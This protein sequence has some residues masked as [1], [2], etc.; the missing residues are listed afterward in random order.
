MFLLILPD[1]SSIVVH[2]PFIQVH[3]LTV[4]TLIV[5]FHL[6]YTN[7]ITTGLDFTLQRWFRLILASFYNYFFD[8]WRE[9]ILVKL[10][11][12]THSYCY[13]TVLL[14]FCIYKD[15]TLI[16][17]DSRLMDRIALEVH[18]PKISQLWVCKHLVHNC[19]SWIGH[20]LWKLANICSI[21]NCLIFNSLYN[22]F[23]SFL[24]S[25]MQRVTSTCSLS[26]NSLND[27]KANEWF[28]KVLVNNYLQK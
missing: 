16:P 26:V 27:W 3:V 9:D 12:L 10:L 13:C 7:Y 24:L 23:C 1:L 20:L 14:T 5:H 25:V 17:A 2:A 15:Y 18:W 22:C 28:V 21:L 11:S 6:D 19:H 4:H 8:K